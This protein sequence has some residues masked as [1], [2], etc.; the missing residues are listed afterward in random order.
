MTSTQYAV[1][2][3]ELGNARTPDQEE[4]APD[5]IVPA[6]AAWMSRA[7]TAI[8]GQAD[9][10]DAMGTQDGVLTE[11]EIRNAYEAGVFE[12]EDGKYALA[13]LLDEHSTFEYLSKT[14]GADSANPGLVIADLK[15]ADAKG[16]IV[17]QVQLENNEVTAHDIKVSAAMQT[18]I[19]AAHAF[20]GTAPVAREAAPETPAGQAEAAPA[21]SEIPAPTGAAGT[22]PAVPYDPYLFRE[23]TPVTEAA[24][25][26]IR[27]AIKAIEQITKAQA[28]IVAQAA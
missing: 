5:T 11:T 8:L 23:I 12:N 2:Y 21:S 4:T 20:F 22:G 25:A 17:G 18:T 1:P 24:G 3:S 6:L 16:E 13:R 15:E 7:L 10:V 14:P 19:D 9:K 28:D 27:D 26:A